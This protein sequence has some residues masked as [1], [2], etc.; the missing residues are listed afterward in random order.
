MSKLVDR[1]KS[2]FS[3]EEGKKVVEITTVTETPKI[4]VKPIEEP[5]VEVKVEEK[6]KSVVKPVVKTEVKTKQVQKSGNKPKTL[7][8]Q[9]KTKK[10]K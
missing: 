6:P 3:K 9:P 2:W 8:P 7:N 5:K 4:P 10:E 1:I